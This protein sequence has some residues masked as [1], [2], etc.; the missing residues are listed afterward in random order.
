[1]SGEKKPEEI[2]INANKIS[3]VAPKYAPKEISSQQGSLKLEIEKDAEFGGIG[4]GVLSDGTPYLNQRGL[5]GR[6][7]T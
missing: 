6:Y 3:I 7:Y 2:I 1:M 5:V 4:M